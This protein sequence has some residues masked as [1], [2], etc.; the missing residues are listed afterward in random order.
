MLF[1]LAVG[2]AADFLGGSDANLNVFIFILV[3]LFLIARRRAFHETSVGDV[4]AC[5]SV[6][7]FHAQAQALQFLNQNPERFWNSGVGNRVAVDDRLV[8]FI[9]ADNIVG[10]DREHF[11]KRIGGAV[12]LQSPHF[13]FPETL[14]AVL[15]FSAH[16]LLRYQGI[17][18]LAARMN[19]IVNHVREFD[20]IHDADGDT[21]VKRFARPPVVENHF[22]VGLHFRFFHDLP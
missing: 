11:P 9:P 4:F 6:N 22:A 12:S 17:G 15:G 21:T 8:Y 1:Y 18:T 10:L 20:H 5:F 16:R 3:F 19:L 2:P 14:A 13:H 7:K